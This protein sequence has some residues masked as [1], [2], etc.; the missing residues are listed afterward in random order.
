M[1]SDDTTRLLADSVRSFLDD[2]EAQGKL[3]IDGRSDGD[4]TAIA[5]E[6]V[7]LGWLGLCLPEALSGL[8]LGLGH[9]AIFGELFGEKAFTHWLIDLSV[10]PSLLVS[11]CPG[12]PQLQR[13]AEGMAAGS[14]CCTFA[15]QESVGQIDCD[16]PATELEGGVLS[17]VK[18]FVPSTKHTS[19]FIVY[20]VDA[21][22]PIIAV[23]P[24][25]S[26]GLA[27]TVDRLSDGSSISRVTFA[28]VRVDD[29]SI[30]VRGAEAVRAVHLVIASATVL[31]AGQLY[32]LAKGALRQ[33][34]AYLHSRS[35]FGQKLSSLQ[36]L[37]H[38]VVDLHTQVRLAEASWRNSLKKFEADPL[39]SSTLAAI[40]AA[41]ART[42]DVALLVCK[43]AIQMHGAIGFTDDADIGRY[44]KAALAW[45]SSFG[46]GAQHRFRFNELTPHEA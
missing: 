18:V 30:M 24:A 15:W 31:R 39:S 44:L 40:S 32:G 27:Q 23:I 14:S 25:D 4:E 12:T 6:M 22:T 46:N 34:V 35:Q 26:L 2:Q 8:G 43:S 16:L 11:S 13:L 20:A 21:G 1:Q 28:K 42:S 9:A 10:I 5:S 19:H 36:V 29:E 3:R 37:Q 7:D 33:T 45:S 41:K 38:R 17:G